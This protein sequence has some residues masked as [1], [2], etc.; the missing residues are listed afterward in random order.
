M[1][2]DKKNETKE[3]VDHQSHLSEVAVGRRFSNSVF[4][5]NFAISTGKFPQWTINFYNTVLSQGTKSA[6]V[7]NIGVAIIPVVWKLRMIKKNQ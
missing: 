4:L 6:R 5:K 2:K 1:L 7:K 3:F